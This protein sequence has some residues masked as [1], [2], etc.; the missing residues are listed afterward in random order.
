MPEDLSDDVLLAVHELAAN[1]VAHSA[2]AGRL[3]IRAA[4]GML[5]CE[6]SDDGP[7][8]G[9]WPLRK[10]H[11]LWLVR[12]V[13]DEVIASSGPYGSQVTVRFGWRAPPGHHSANAQMT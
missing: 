5:R 4:A 8:A 10:G 3:L 9:P 1:V 13:A 7:G 6:I 2:G 12:E 11:G